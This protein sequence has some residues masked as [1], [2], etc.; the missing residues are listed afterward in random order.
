[1]LGILDYISVLI[2]G[3][4]IMVFFLDIKI[5][6]KSVLAVS[7]YVLISGFLQLVLYNVFGTDALEKLYP[8]MIHLPVVIFFVYI[9][10]KRYNLVFFVLFISY[11]FTAPRRWIGE[12]VASFFNNDAYIL[13]VTK[14]VVSILLLIV[15]Y[16][17]L[18][19]FVNRILNYS[20]KRIT[21]LTVVPAVSYC[22]TYA[23]TV[24][25][26]ALYNSNMLVVG[27]FSVGFNLVFYTFIIAYFIEMDKSFMLQTEQT[28]LEMQIDTIAIQIEDYKTSQKQ[29]R[30]YR[31]D[32]RHHLHYI[33]A[34]IG[35]NHTDEALAYITQINK[36]IEATQVREYCENTSI[37][38][39][40]STYA[41][42]AKNNHIDIEIDAVVPMASAVHAIDVCIILSNAIENAIHAS[43][44]IVNE[45]N[46]KIRVSCK[47]ENKKLMIEICNNYEG[48]IQ[49]EEN[50]PVS[51][52][53]DHGLGVKSIITTVKKYQGLYAFTEENG[54]FTMR[55]IL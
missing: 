27:L 22:I 13:V 35:D 40:L 6:R 55:V 11:I 48:E 10:K 4:L 47:V 9:F 25:T 43:Q 42:K 16:R 18:R 17:V 52:E 20:S 54:V 15:M 5:N 8:L 14:I 26:D 46:K 36:D 50:I 21:L 28:V 39:I 38:L 7:L 32:L 33:S 23:T 29:G 51:T 37:N 3:V 34:C 12:V 31:H 53:K 30:I 44:K 2:Y 41:T 45:H 49:F 24:Y 19:P 1:M